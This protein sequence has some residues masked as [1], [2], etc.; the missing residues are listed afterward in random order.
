MTKLTIKGLQE[1]CNQKQIKY[2]PK[3]KGET[4]DDYKAKLEALINKKETKAITG[5]S[6]A[7]EY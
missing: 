5:K 1:V 2:P 3:Q 7:G 6:F 4:A